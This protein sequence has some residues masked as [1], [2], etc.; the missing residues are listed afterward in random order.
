MVSDIDI[1]LAQLQKIRNNIA[2]S[3]KS[4]KPRCLTLGG[5]NITW[6]LMKDAYNWD[7]SSFSLPLHEKLTPLHLE[8]DPAARM[9]NHLAED[10]L[11]RKRF[12][13]MQVSYYQY[14]IFYIQIIVATKTR[15]HHN[16]ALFI[17]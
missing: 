16:P 10:L 11:D 7:Q 4:K 14:A 12:F 6:Q 15:I 17:I 13:L 9:R 8:L 2:K 3:N 5:K 1:F